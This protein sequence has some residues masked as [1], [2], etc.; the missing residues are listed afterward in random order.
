MRIE[1]RDDQG[2][3][4]GAIY[5]EDAF[6]AVAVPQRGDLVALAAIAGPS[7]VPAPQG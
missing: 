2:K 6:E 3:L 1:L 5:C 7:A 4:V